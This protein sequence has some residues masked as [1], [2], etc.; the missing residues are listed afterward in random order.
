MKKNIDHFDTMPA[1]TSPQTPIP[2]SMPADTSPQT[3]IPASMLGASPITPTPLYGAS[4]PTP[5]PMYGTTHGWA[6]RSQQA[7]ANKPRLL[8]L[9]EASYLITG[10]S[11]YRLRMLCISGKLRHHRFGNK[12][13]VSE[14]AVLQYFSE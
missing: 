9:K 1:D 10:L 4:P 12:Y 11:E 6:V 8:T 13:M 7:Q 14:K 3:P 5:V 2:A